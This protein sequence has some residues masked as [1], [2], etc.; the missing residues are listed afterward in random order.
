MS[1]ERMVAFTRRCQGS[2]LLKG[3]GPRDFDLTS[4]D[5]EFCCPH[6]GKPL[7]LSLSLSLLKH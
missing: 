5:N 2:G 3:G 7:S 4:G 6:L 1:T